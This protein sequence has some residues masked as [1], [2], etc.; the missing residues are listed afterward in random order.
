MDARD[1]ATSTR[2]I[3]CLETVV[4]GLVSDASNAFLRDLISTVITLA[5][6]GRDEIDPVNPDLSHV[7]IDFK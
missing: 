4:V 5:I 1:E 2:I 6:N 3:K 7:S